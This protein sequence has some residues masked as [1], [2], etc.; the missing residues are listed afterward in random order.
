MV[1]WDVMGIKA[2]TATATDRVVVSVRADICMCF[3]SRTEAGPWG[4]LLLSYWCR[5]DNRTEGSSLL[6]LHGSSFL[7][8]AAHCEQLMVHRGPRQ[9]VGDGGGLGGVI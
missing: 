8:R 2:V 1:N 9:Q 5:E 4:C 7:L 3:W 6:C